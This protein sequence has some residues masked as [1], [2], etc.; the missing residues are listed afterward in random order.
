MLL[1]DSD[2]LF[3][4]KPAEILAW[5]ESEKS[6]TWFNADFQ[7]SC[8]ITAAQAHEKW[9][10]KLWPLVNAGLALVDLSMV[11]LAF[12]EAC[13]RE[14]TIRT[15]GWTW[16]I[17]QTLYALCASRAGRGGL[18]P[19]SYEVSF[20]PQAAPD[21]A[22]RHYVGYVRT[23]FLSEG[24]ERLYRSV[25]AGDKGARRSTCHSILGQ[26]TPGQERSGKMVD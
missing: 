7:D 10:I 21:I 8:N 19:P 15:Q 2:V 23:Q 9:G 17:E 26:T 3:F 12:C 6:E 1:F 22:A 16:C 24:I 4:R 5:V 14:G 25:L 11:D 20:N 13:L 18:L